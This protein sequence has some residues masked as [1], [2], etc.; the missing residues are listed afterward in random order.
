MQENPHCSCADG[1]ACKVTR[2]IDIDGQTA[3]IKQCMPVNEPI[4][5]EKLTEDDV[6]ETLNPGSATLEQTARFYPGK[7]C[8][9]ASDCFWPNTCCMFNKRCGL[10]LLKYFTCYFKSVHKCG[11]MDDLVCKTTTHVTLPIVK[12]PF[13]IRQCVPKDEA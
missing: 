11:C 5:V 9:S 13:P 6:K 3:I 7:K 12:I 8:T 4:V 10:K 1:L 2:E